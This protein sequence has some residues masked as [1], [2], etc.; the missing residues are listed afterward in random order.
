M[1]HKIQSIRNLT[2]STYIIRLDR[3]NFDFRAGQYL[4]LGIPDDINMREYSIYSGV[5]D[6]YLEVL[7]KEIKQ[8]DV[9]VVLKKSHPG[10]ALHVSGPYGFFTL[11]D[12]NVREK[13]FLFLASGTGISPFHSFVKSYPTL[14]YKIIHGIRYNSETYE[15]ESYSAGNYFAAVSQDNKAKIKG[16][17]TEYLKTLTLE[18]STLCYLCGNV[19]MIHDAYEIL[20]SKGIPVDQIH[21]EVYF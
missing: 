1:L 5:N 16:R 7:I 2:D 21:S 4:S 13:K 8:G 11:P 18:P 19:D 9:S 6:P 20:Q 17:L 15:K 12:Q 14:D 10:Q 3:N